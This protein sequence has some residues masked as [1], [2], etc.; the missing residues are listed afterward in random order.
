MGATD[1]EIP[2]L[3][4]RRIRREYAGDLFCRRFAFLG[5]AARKHIERLGLRH[6]H[7]ID[8][9]FEAHP[10]RRAAADVA[11]TAG[12]QVGGLDVGAQFVRRKGREGDPRLEGAAVE[13]RIFTGSLERKRDAAEI[14]FGHAV[15]T[16]DK[17]LFDVGLRCARLA[18]DGGG[19]VADAVTDLRDRPDEQA[20]RPGHGG[21]A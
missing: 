15:G 3:Q 13:M 19:D 14:V 17:E 11:G 18:T 9:E 7:A 2:S 16:A 12:E 6:L 21:A 5:I 4:Q 1:V 10:V 8:G 20:G